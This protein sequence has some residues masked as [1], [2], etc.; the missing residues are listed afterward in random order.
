M[1]MGSG[2]ELGVGG[3]KTTKKELRDL[4]NAQNDIEMNLTRYANADAKRTREGYKDKQKTEAFR[5]IDDVSFSLQLHESVT[6][7]AKQLFATYRDCREQ[8]QALKRVE[9]ACLITAFYDIMAQ[10]LSIKKEKNDESIQQSSSKR[11]KI[12]ESLPKQKSYAELHPFQCK[13][14]ERRFNNKKMLRIHS[15]EHKKGKA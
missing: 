9:A 2:G 8:L 15:R 12:M 1:S 11:P 3:T 4:R 14:C 5:V 10:G 6:Q 13:V 7:R